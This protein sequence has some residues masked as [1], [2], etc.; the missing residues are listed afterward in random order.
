M[1]DRPDG[2][3]MRTALASCFESPA[4]HPVVT[5]CYPE[6]DEISGEMAL[7]VVARAWNALRR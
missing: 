5:R 2:N 4:G 6:G 3:G 1:V 7:M